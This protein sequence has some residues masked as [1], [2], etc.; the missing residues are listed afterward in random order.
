M[1]KFIL[2]GLLAITLGASGCAWWEEPV[3]EFDIN[4]EW[5][6][7]VKLGENPFLF[8]VYLTR[9]GCQDGEC[10]I[11]GYF[12]PP[13]ID[14]EFHAIQGRYYYFRKP[15]LG[16]KPRDLIKLSGE[17]PKYVLWDE[18]PLPIPPEGLKPVE[19]E[20][21]LTGYPTYEL[22]PKDSYWSGTIVLHG[23]SF[24]PQGQ[25]WLVRF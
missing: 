25:A 6:F 1:K 10:A 9:L 19:F 17:L 14:G 15:F 4:G 7:E 24:S 2:I 18:L 20:A 11:T 22:P 8:A 23:A 5:A 12:S 16:E 13:Y 3:P 21:W